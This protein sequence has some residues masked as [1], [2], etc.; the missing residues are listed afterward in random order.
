MS[1]PAFLSSVPPSSESWRLR[2]VLGTPNTMLI[3][4]N[5]VMD[6]KKK[7]TLEEVKLQ[8][9]YQWTKLELLFE[10]LKNV[11]RLKEQNLCMLEENFII[12]LK[13]LTWTKYSC[14]WKPLMLLQ[15]ISTLHFVKKKK[16]LLL[17]LENNCII[18]IKCKGSEF[19]YR[20]EMS[21]W[22]WKKR[23]SIPRPFTA[24]ICEQRFLSTVNLKTA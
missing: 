3:C 4:V 22:H 20:Q 18:C 13:H 12:L 2:V 14:V 8:V 24:S 9:G 7:L 19:Y 1:T 10:S 21:F 6:S 5:H 23:W 15:G 16:A 11:L 17:D